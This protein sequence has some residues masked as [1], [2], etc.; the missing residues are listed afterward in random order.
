MI[1]ALPQDSVRVKSPSPSPSF[2]FAAVGSS[3]L[4]L[5][6]LCSPCRSLSSGPEGSLNAPVHL[7]ILSTLFHPHHLHPPVSQRWTGD[8]RLPSALLLH[9]RSACP[10]AFSP[11]C[12]T[13]LCVGDSTDSASLYFPDAL[14]VGLLLQGR[15]APHMPQ[16]VP[17]IDGVYQWKGPDNR[18]TNFCP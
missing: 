17:V 7:P 5:Y 9:D 11:R 15:N 13:V 2:E 16:H 18:A 8:V 10:S 14:C 6:T 4:V 3:V 1:V 12:M